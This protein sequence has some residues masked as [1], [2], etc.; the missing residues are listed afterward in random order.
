MSFLWLVSSYLAYNHHVVGCRRD[1]SVVHIN[2]KSQFKD[3][4]TAGRC[5]STR[6][7]TKPVNGSCRKKSAGASNTIR[8]AA[9][10]AAA[11]S[12]SGFVTAGAYAA[13]GGGGSGA[14]GRK[15]KKGRGSGSG[16]GS[17]K[18]SG[19]KRRK[20]GGGSSGQWRYR[21]GRKVGLCPPV[22][23]LRLCLCLCAV[24]VA[25]GSHTM[26]MS[27][28]GCQQLVTCSNSLINHGV[29]VM[30][31]FI[32]GSGKQLTGSAAW[33]RYQQGKTKQ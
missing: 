5:A 22:P 14:K 23:A 26:S 8:A 1:G 12:S 6:T 13:A 9:A 29:H 4:T 32:D 27:M 25:I 18:G 21:G 28:F 10:A 2:Y 16:S 15:A 11:G 3:G 17:A 7:K 33:G 30:Q 24:L 20:K 31:V 19:S